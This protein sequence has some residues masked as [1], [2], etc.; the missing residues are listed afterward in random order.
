[1]NLYNDKKTITANEINKFCYCPYQWYYERVYGIKELRRLA[2]ERN[3][4]Y[5]FADSNKSNFIKGIE[6]HSNLKFKNGIKLLIS[7]VI[8]LLILVI[9]FLKV[10]G[11]V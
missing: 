5:G 10:K 7:A 8:V 2:N 9:Y 1:M 3:E 6:Y 4:L 11:I